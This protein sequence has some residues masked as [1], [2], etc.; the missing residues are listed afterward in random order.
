MPVLESILVLASH[1][2]QGQRDLLFLLLAQSG[3]AGPGRLY[4]LVVDEER[5]PAPGHAVRRIHVPALVKHE[6]GVD[7]FTL[8]DSQLVNPQIDLS[9]PR[10]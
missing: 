2:I 8:G 9:G 6:A 3:R 5:T 4:H 10:E 7:G 1:G